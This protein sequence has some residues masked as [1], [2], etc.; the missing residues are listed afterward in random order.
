MPE[1]EREQKETDKALG[2]SWRHQ[3]H[4]GPWRDAGCC[5]KRVLA[6]LR[7]AKIKSCWSSY[8]RMLFVTSDLPCPSLCSGLYL[9]ASVQILGTAAGS[10][11]AISLLGGFLLLLGA[12]KKSKMQLE[13]QVVVA[14]HERK[15]CVLSC[16]PPHPC[17]EHAYTC[18][19]WFFFLT[20]HSFLLSVIPKLF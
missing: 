11:H 14:G 20:S 9:S 10:S 18:V 2:L 7:Y 15:V 17:A 1:V 3:C 5:A 12:G 16:A 19:F 8:E 13:K 4:L 6:L